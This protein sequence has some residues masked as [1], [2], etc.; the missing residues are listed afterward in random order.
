MPG[1]IDTHVHIGWHFD[2][3]DGRSHDDETDRDETPQE[4]VDAITSA[5]SLAAE[6]LGLG[7]RVGTI[8][9]GYEADLIA[10]DGDPLRDINALSHVAFV[11]KGGRI[12]RR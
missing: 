4:S 1:G 2:A 10:V 11:M 12:I 9:A 8:A 3:R 7:D 5:T 6:S